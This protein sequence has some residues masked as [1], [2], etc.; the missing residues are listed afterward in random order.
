[1]DG[2]EADYEEQRTL[3]KAQRRLWHAH[4]ERHIV[5]VVYEAD[6]YEQEQSEWDPWI[7]NDYGEL[8]ALERHQLAA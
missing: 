6:L 7:P 8:S 1:M 2:V 5:T 4:L 3:I